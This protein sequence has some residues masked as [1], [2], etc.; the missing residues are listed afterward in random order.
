MKPSPGWY[1]SQLIAAGVVLLIVITGLVFSSTDLVDEGV[2]PGVFLMLVLTFAVFPGLLVSLLVNQLILSRRRVQALTRGEK[3]VLGIEY[4]L[5]AV[6]LLGAWDEGS[7]LWGGLFVVPLLV[8]TAVVACAMIS[9]ATSRFRRGE[10]FLAQAAAPVPA[11]GPA[12][13]QRPAS[14][15]PADDFA[16]PPPPY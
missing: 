13:A 2:V 9:V 10:L 6:L 11:P 14:A 7:I 4:G 8:I 1:W 16:P 12:P 5:T 3:I 15:P